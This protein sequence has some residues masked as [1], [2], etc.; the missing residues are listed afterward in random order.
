MSTGRNY[1]ILF[2]VYDVHRHVHTRLRRQ[3]QYQRILGNHNQAYR[4][5]TP[6]LT[7]DGSES[8]TSS[9]VSLTENNLAEQ[10][11]DS[12]K[13]SHRAQCQGECGG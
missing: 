6:V 8:R 5:N 4:N 3:S 1:A 2:L 11:T 12:K 13:R 7:E 10:A 9:K